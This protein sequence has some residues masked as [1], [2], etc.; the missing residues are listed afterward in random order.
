MRHREIDATNIGV[1]VEKGIVTLSGRVQTRR[2]KK[3][4]E[5]TIE[6]LPGLQDVRN[7]LSVIRGI[8]T[9]RGPDAAVK[10][11]LGLS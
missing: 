10:K 5:F 11:D 4:A 8:D 9:D 1:K 7:E 3:L 6:D 2:M